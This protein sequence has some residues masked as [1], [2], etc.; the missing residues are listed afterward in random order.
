[1]KKAYLGDALDLAKGAVLSALPATCRDGLAVAPMCT[2]TATWQAED[3]ET[4]R[5]LLR[6][7]TGIPIQ[8]TPDAYARNRFEGI[9]TDARALFLDPNTGV[10]ARR[11]PD[12]VSSA[13]I[14]DLLTAVRPRVIVAYQHSWRSSG[15]LP[16]ILASLNRP[17]FAYDASG[18]AFVYVSNSAELLATCRSV[19]AESLGT[20]SS[21]LSSAGAPVG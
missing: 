3:R 13:E 11:G 5:L 18:V 9:S 1:M 8:W 21:R 4:Y 20:A 12:H 14:D 16:A 6:L 15:Y 19:L 7:T 10:A 17:A 2:D